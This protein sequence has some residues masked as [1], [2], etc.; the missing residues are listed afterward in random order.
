VH[1][2]LAL[3]MLLASV[4]G[5]APQQA[6]V[7]Q[8]APAP[9]SFTLQVDPQLAA[10]VN[11][12]LAH[13][14]LRTELA[15]PAGEAPRDFLER[16]C[17][18]HVPDYQVVLDPRE[19]TS[20]LRFTPCARIRRDLRV[21]ASA[22]DTLEDIA[23]RH[24][25]PRSAAVLLKVFSGGGA[26]PNPAPPARLKAGD[27]V[28]IPEAPV[29][30]RV[31]VNPEVVTDRASLVSAVASALGCGSEEPEACLA[32]RNVTVLNG[33]N[34][35]PPE[36]P[37][38][39]LEPERFLPR[40]DLVPWSPRS[41]LSTA[42]AP[43]GAAEAA[44]GAEQPPPTAA[45]G[46][47]TPP[48]P[49]P[50]PPPPA[51]AAVAPTSPSSAIPVAPDQ[52]PYDA[53]L[54][55][56]ILADAFHGAA[57]PVP[58]TI[59]VADGGLG[60]WQGAPL[61]PDAFKKSDEL[62]DAETHQRQEPDHVDNDQNGFVDDLFGAGMERDGG[63]MGTGDLGLCEGRQP[64]FTA[65]ASSPLREASHGTVV[66][67]IAAALGLRKL[68]PEVAEALPKLTFFRMLPRSVCTQDDRLDFREAE[69]VSAFNYLIDQSNVI[70]I[71]YQIASDQSGLQFALFV[72]DRLHDVLL[73]LP[74]GDGLPGDLD[75]SRACPP[76]LGNPEVG[77]SAA[78]YTLVVGAATRDL[79]RRY[80]SNFGERTV[81]LFAPGEP[82]DA[83]DLAE[84]PVPETDVATS[85]AAPLAALAAAI[86]RSFGDKNSPKDIK[87]R[88]MATTWPLDDADSRPERTHVGVLDL[89][90]AVAVRHDAVEV[91]ETENGQRVRRTF[92]GRLLT[93][94]EKLG[95]CAGNS[96]SE[97]AVHAIRLE[98]PPAEG[99]SGERTLLIYYR[100]KM[101]Q[102]IQ[103]RLIMTRRCRPQGEL[104]IRT[105]TQGD[106]K[107]E[108]KTFPLS[109]VTQ[110]QLKWLL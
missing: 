27:A 43:P 47:P 76:C 79:R 75:S 108:D 64:H 87:D 31:T 94:L 41:G 35:P 109:M 34:V 13:I 30:T 72:K 45:A 88:L 17:G 16:F 77:G 54:V 33:A 8:P 21:K 91:V 32:R 65:W 4:E 5:P 71:S 10:R 48:A 14:A 110:I 11:E 39:P 37:R 25:L 36:P 7:G 61:P 81:G 89:V 50:P 57:P 104:R 98:D 42:V 95:I 59:G 29:L 62:R 99:P 70:S 68:A 96:F 9:P 107:E 92:V 83:L 51:P 74:A 58:A 19:S 105:L 52:W 56:A 23:V 103:R 100:N 20:T 3:A 44:A 55:A 67:S 78:K 66:A 97:G 24:G 84:Q 80:D 26:T 101:D 1:I 38:P 46:A 69:M 12:V 28:V 53:A 6:P 22:G 18:G 86:I 73:V 49:P 102:G 106:K 85:W 60:D 40:M 93:P 82:K 2:P 90:K 15:L 63:P